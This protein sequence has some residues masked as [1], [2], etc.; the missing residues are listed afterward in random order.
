MHELLYNVSDLVNMSNK[1]GN[2]IPCCG[3]SVLCDFSSF[4]VDIPSKT[5]FHIVQ[6]SGN[7]VMNL[8]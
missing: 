8:N 2:G 6:N 1:S 3:A 7:Y 4:V 5:F